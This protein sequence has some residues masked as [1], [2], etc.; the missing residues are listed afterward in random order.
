M[1]DAVLAPPPPRRRAHPVPARVSMLEPDDIARDIAALHLSCPDDK[2][3]RQAAV[4]IFRSAYDRG[5]A[6]IRAALENNGRGLVCA[7]HISQLEDDLIR[8]IHDYAITHVHPPA[9]TSGERLCIV[10]VGGYGRGTLAPG[11]DIDL[12]FLMPGRPSGEVDFLFN[13]Q[14]HCIR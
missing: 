4:E 5:L 10:A 13:P 11:S 1:T 9:S 12:L 3:F 8:A 14:P 2:A 7:A 6:L